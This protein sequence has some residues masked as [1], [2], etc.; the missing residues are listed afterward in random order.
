ME[1]RAPAGL[2][3]RGRRDRPGGG[4]GRQVEARPA[5]SPAGPLPR[6]LR[7]RRP[8]RRHTPG[9]RL[10]L[11]RRRHGERRPSVTGAR[12]L[13]PRLAIALSAG[14]RA[15]SPEPREKRPPQPWTRC[16]GFKPGL[17]RA[18][19]LAR[20]PADARHRLRVSLPTRAFHLQRNAIAPGRDHAARLERLLQALERSP[21]LLGI[22]R[23][24]LALHAQ[25]VREVARPREVV[26]QVLLELPGPRLLLRVPLGP[27]DLPDG[28][29]VDR[30]DEE[31]LERARKAMPL[32]AL[33]D[34]LG[35]SGHV[36]RA[37]RDA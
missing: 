20:S 10:G 33:R 23:L 8:R 28:D 25:A 31:H 15:R 13:S 17:L 3:R 24:L 27:V 16:P 30:R 7:R 35:E 9:R 29:D 26:A 2:R 14:C 5:H 19:V 37:A 11:Q 18:G 21:P 1:L 32:V 12:G 36:F 6:R 22:R 4:P 34:Q